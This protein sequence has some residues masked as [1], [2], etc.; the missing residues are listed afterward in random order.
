MSP[1]SA[2]LLRERRYEIARAAAARMLDLE[3]VVAERYGPE[4]IRLFIEESAALVSQLSQAIV[5]ELPS[6]FEDY[7]AWAR[8]TSV[9]ARIAESHFITGLLTIASVL[10][11]FVPTQQ[12]VTAN[13]YIERVVRGFHELSAPPSTYI[14]EKQRHGELARKL[15]EATIHYQGEEAVALVESA[16]GAGAAVPDIFVEVFQP[17]LYEIGL[18]WQTGKLPVAREHHAAGVLQLL[19]DQLETRLPDQP[20][21]YGSAVVACAPGELHDLGPRMVAHMLRA[22]GWQVIFLGANVPAVA[23][24]E[25]LEQTQARLLCLSISTAW[26]LDEAA[27]VISA[28]RRTFARPPVKIVAGGYV[29]NRVPDIWSRIGADAYAADARAAVHVCASVVDRK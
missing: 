21:R 6:L 27:D 17:V 9:G 25:S 20:A 15:I 29:L 8:T 2:N 16:L 4:G 24:I 11:D 23:V 26:H 12:A 28:V 1:I 10:T 19:I 5:V 22:A 18:R 13:D 14:D 7:V 3:P